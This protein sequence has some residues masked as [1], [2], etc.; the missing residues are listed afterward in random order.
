M[1]K[2][3]I[4]LFALVAYASA[5]MKIGNG[6]LDLLK[7]SEGWR[8]DYY[9]DQIGLKT[10]GYGHACV[11]HNNCNDIGKTPLTQQQGVDLLKKDLVEYENCVNNAVSGLNQNQFD[12]CVDFTFNMGCQAFQTS[13]I[14]KNI[15]AKNMQAAANS[16]DKYNVAAG[17]VIEGLT[18][19][20]ANDKKLFLKK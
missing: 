9:I 1:A 17:Q 12:A 20:R 5:G 19:R 11:W 10:I 16:F 15:K 14:L 3:L 2:Q 18:V 13:D 6:G 8:A 7:F 4:V